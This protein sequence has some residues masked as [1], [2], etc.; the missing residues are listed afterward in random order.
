MRKETPNFGIFIGN[1]RQ[2]CLPR[3][4]AKKFGWKFRWS[5]FDEPLGVFK[6]S[7]E[8]WPLSAL[9]IRFERFW[10]PKARLWIYIEA[11]YHYA[12]VRRQRIKQKLCLFWDLQPGSPPHQQPLDAESKANNLQFCLSAPTTHP[13]VLHVGG[14]FLFVFIIPGNFNWIPIFAMILLQNTLYKYQ[15]IMSRV[16]LLKKY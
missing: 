3:V 1:Q 14:E 4:L 12:T 16:G 10:P 7:W 11:V 6:G 2:P 15:T 13:L 5:N 8:F 9:K